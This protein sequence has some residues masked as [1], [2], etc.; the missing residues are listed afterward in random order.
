[1]WE[2]FAS[3]RLMAK[4][5]AVGDFESAKM[6]GKRSVGVGRFKKLCS[7]NKILFE[8]YRFIKRI[9]D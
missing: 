3:A 2:G 1:M 4:A 9:K 7:Q 8:T 6:Y 5:F